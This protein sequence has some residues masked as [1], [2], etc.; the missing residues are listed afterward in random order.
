MFIQRAD[1]K[2]TLK[3]RI[4]KVN[5]KNALKE[6]IQR[7]HTKSTKWEEHVMRRVHNRTDRVHNYSKPANKK[8]I[9]KD[10]ITEWKE[11]WSK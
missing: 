3:E 10:S 11:P 1:T 9:F 5:T 7:A 6:H 4:K 2:S 8:S